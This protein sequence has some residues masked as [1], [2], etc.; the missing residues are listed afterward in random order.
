MILGA[1]VLYE[2][3]LVPLVAN[4]LARMLAPGGLALIADP[5]R[6]AAEGFPA[7][8]E[9]LGRGFVCENWP[10][11]AESEELALFEGRCIG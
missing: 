10:I 6:V 8:V 4:L 9:G 2:R 3:R 11:A 7:A 1:D 5:Y